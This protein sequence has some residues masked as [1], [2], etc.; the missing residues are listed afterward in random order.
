MKMTVMKREQQDGREAGEDL[1]D[2]LGVRAKPRVHPDLDA[3][4][5]PDERRDDDQDDDPGE[6]GEAR[7]ANSVGEGAEAE[8]G[9][10][11]QP[12]RRPRT[13]RPPTMTAQKTTSPAAPARRPGKRVFGQAERT[14]DPVEDAA[15]GAQTLA[16][17]PGDGDRRRKSRTTLR[18]LSADSEVSIR[19]FSAQATSGR[20]NTKFVP[21]TRITMRRDGD[22]HLRLRA[23]GD[24]RADVAADAGQ[25]SVMPLPSMRR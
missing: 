15:D 17:E 14:G 1:H 19:N 12:R 4:R 13:P 5:H 9:A 25:V 2:G 24:G 16:E 21:T 18:G 22:D 23:L 20:K 3:D 8:V 10:G 11:R 7:V 6:G